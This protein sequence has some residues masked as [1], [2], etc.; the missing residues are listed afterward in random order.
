MTATLSAFPEPELQPTRA[1]DWLRTR[2]D[3]F[4]ADARHLELPR[5]GI[6]GTLLSVR[7]GMTAQQYRAIA[8]ELRDCARDLERGI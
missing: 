4:E 2:A 1:I 7:D 3:G 5:R 8:A 6:P